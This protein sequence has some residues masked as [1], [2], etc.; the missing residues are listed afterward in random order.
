MAKPTTVPM[1]KAKRGVALLLAVANASVLTV[2]G[3][4]SAAAA[5]IFSTNPAP[6]A[7]KTASMGEDFSL[8]TLLDTHF[9]QRKS[10]GKSTRGP[11][12]MPA[13][14]ELTGGGEAQPTDADDTLLTGGGAL[15]EGLA[16]EG[17]LS[18]SPA[19]TP[20]APRKTGAGQ[21]PAGAWRNGGAG[22]AGDPG[23]TLSLA[24]GGAPDWRESLRDAAPGSTAVPAYLRTSAADPRPAAGARTPAAVEL[25]AVPLPAPGA[26]L[27]GALALP[28]ALRLGR[29]RRA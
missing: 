22:G 8:D 13:S 29:R 27:L 14:P 1:I 24:G 18:W 19:I 17:G 21:G 7:E 9:T 6:I 26:L 12:A 11:T 16:L 23:V 25:P 28:F 4:G 3:M 20:G 2:D 15:L 10:A 5:V